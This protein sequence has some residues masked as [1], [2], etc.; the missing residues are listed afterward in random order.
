MNTEEE[1]T[2]WISGT[3]ALASMGLTVD[4][5]DDADKELLARKSYGTD[6]Q[7]CLCGHGVSRH[8][9]TNGVVFCKPARMECPCKRVRPVLITEDTRMFI[10]KTDG[11]GSAHALARGIRA[12]VEKNKSVSWS[13]DLVCDRCGE[14]DNNIVPAAVTQSGNAVSYATGYDALLCPECR[15]EV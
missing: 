9:V 12:T 13:I 8:T 4:D 1:N 2:K 6:R 11:S 7:I 10:R 14:S 5:I 15:T 3:D